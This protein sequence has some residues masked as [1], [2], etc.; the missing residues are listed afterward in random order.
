MC[1][2]L[3]TPDTLAGLGQEWEPSPQLVLDRCA[4][5]LG[6]KDGAGGILAVRRGSQGSYVLDCQDMECMWHVPCVHTDVLDPTGK[7]ALP[8]P[9]ATPRTIARWY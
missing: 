7:S 6:M 4:E 1:P 8:I 5:M 3:S 2:V 9:H